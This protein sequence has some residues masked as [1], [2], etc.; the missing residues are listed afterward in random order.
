MA[1]DK[2][3]VRI[4]ILKYVGHYEAGQE[5]DVSEDEA[6]KLCEVREKHDGEKAVKFQNAITVEDFEKAKS[7]P[8]DKGGLT[9]EEVRALG[10]KN[11]VETPKDK[12]F[13]AKLARLRKE[14]EPEVSESVDEDGRA[15]AKKLAADKKAGKKSNYSQEASA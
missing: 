2:K 12:A 5:V 8:I 14:N 3:T 4:K 10:D 15:Q 1:N 9:L 6:A 7:A 11:V 13:E